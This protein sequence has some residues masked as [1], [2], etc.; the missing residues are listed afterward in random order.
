MSY[1]RRVGAVRMLL[2]SSLALLGV[3]LAS[4]TPA[5]AISSEEC[6]VAKGKLSVDL[7]GT[8]TLMAQLDGTFAG[9]VTV[10]VHC[11]N[12]GGTSLGLIPNAVVTI[13]T[14]VPNA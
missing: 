7:E 1:P 13:S 8:P 6:G 5:G 9:P 3:V 14:T 2:G 11:K 10:R 12:N 4:A